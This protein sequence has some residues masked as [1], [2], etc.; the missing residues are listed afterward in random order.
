MPGKRR[1]VK[2]ATA[3]RRT[4]SKELTRKTAMK[5]RHW[6]VKKLPLPEFAPGYHTYIRRFSAK[7]TER[8]LALRKDLEN[9][10]ALSARAAAAL[11]VV[12]VCDRH[13]SPLFGKDDIEQ[14]LADWTFAAIIRCATEIADFNGISVVAEGERKKK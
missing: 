7:G 11:C 14:L 10:D 1:K 8:L 3:K 4:A 12:G 9:E 2:K 13:G 6:G 5:A